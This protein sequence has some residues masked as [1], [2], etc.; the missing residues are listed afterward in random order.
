M[1]LFLL[2]Q[3]LYTILLEYIR[4]EILDGNYILLH[5][6]SLKLDSLN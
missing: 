6:I 3:L 1:L 5:E 2:A 4:K